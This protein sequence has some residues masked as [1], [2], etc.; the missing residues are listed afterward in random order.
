MIVHAIATLTIIP[1]LIKIIKLH[2]IPLA[3]VGATAWR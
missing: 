3:L 1:F 2:D